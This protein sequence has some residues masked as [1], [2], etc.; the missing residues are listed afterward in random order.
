MNN[1]Y[2]Q[3]LIKKIITS[4][5]T[6]DASGFASLFAEDAEIQLNQ[7]INISKN[8]IEAVTNNYFAELQFITIKLL[9]LAINNE[10]N[11]AFVEWVWSDY[12]LKKQRHNS[13]QNVISLKFKNNLIYRWREYH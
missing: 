7:E 3:L 11:I 1:N 13:H 8:E 12:N 5:E 6:K 2:Y 10:E 9:G 4:C